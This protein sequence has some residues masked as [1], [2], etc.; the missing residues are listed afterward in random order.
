MACRFWK[1]STAGNTTLFVDKAASPAAAMRIVGAEQAAFFSGNRLEMAGGEMCVNACLA[2]AALL[3][4]TPDETARIMIAGHEVEVAAAGC[5]PEWLCRAAFPADLCAPEVRQ[6]ITV[7]HM[8][9]IS[10]A[11]IEKTD[12]SATG[13]VF[14][15]AAELR[16]RLDL[17]TCAA[18]GIVWWSRQGE[19]CEITPVVSVPAAGT[20]NLEGACGSASVALAALLPPGKYRVRQPSGQILEVEAGSGTITVSAPVRLMAKGMLWI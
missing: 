13:D 11:L 20:C 9:G 8:N 17:D 12:S 1:F 3:D 15:L 10:H 2:F 14:A 19:D 18:A 16:G 7:Q 6:G 5:E 4:L